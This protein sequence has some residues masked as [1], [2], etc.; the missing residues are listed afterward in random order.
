MPLPVVR[1]SPCRADDLEPLEAWAPTGNSRTHAA[2]F[3][4]QQA[5]TSTY[6]LAVAPDLADGFV[7]SAE[8]RWDGNANPE[9]PRCPEVNGLQVWPEELQSHGIGTAMLALLEQEA[10]ARDHAELGLGVDSA[11]PLPL[12]LR[13]GYVDAGVRYLDRYTWIDEDHRQHHVAEPRRWLIKH[14]EARR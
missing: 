8:I 10:H 1:L 2:R 13:L 4:R 6:F 5:G 14:L 3:A 9:V 7:G 12:Y 11:G